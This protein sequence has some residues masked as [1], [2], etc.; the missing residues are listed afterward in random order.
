MRSEFKKHPSYGRIV[1]T[2][3]HAGGGGKNSGGAVLFGSKVRH[4]SFISIEIE[5]AELS[6]DGFGEY[7][8][9]TGRPIV[10]LSMSEAQWAHMISSFG[11]G[12]GTPITI[13]GLEGVG[14]IESPPEQVPVIELANKTAEKVKTDLVKKLRDLER[15]VKTISEKGA[16]KKALAQLAMDFN[17]LASFLDG[18]FDYLENQVKE[19]MEKEVAKANIE[20]EA[21]ITNAVTRLGER[22]LGE[23]LAA[24]DKSALPQLC[25]GEGNE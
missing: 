20:I 12:G 24:G 19:R 6:E 14:I 21:L 2:K 25:R 13:T 5:R 7:V 18:N 16:G 3:T 23:R 11:D 17:I 10:R 15:D 4:P 1:L 8:H 9:G 22:A